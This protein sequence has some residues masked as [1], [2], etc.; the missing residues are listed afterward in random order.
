[1][2]LYSG[3][4]THKGVLSRNQ[5]LLEVCRNSSTCCRWTQMSN[6]GYTKPLCWDLA[7]APS[8]PV[9]TPHR[10]PLGYFSPRGLGWGVLGPKEKALHQGGQA[11]SQSLVFHNHN[12]PPAP[13]SGC[14]PSTDTTQLQQFILCCSWNP[15]LCSGTGCPDPKEPVS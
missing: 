15:R 12:V 5:C 11:P 1:M 9:H 6:S 13:G 8:S 10:K 3:K 2:K 14:C 7:A 4:Q